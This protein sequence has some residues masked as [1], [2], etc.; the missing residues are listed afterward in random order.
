MTKNSRESVMN[1]RRLWLLV[2]IV[3]LL[4]G[5][6]LFVYSQS[7][8][9]FGD[10]GFHLLAAQL[11]NAGKAPYIDF[12]YQQ[13]PLYPFL[14]GRWM[15]IFGETWRSAHV[16]SVLLVFSTT[17]VLAGILFS[18]SQ[19]SN[20][21]QAISIG[22]LLFFALDTQ[23]YDLSL[24]ADPYVLCLLLSVVAY[25]V[26]IRA[27]DGQRPYLAFVAGLFASGSAASSLLTAPIVIVL[28]T[29]LLQRSVS[30][31][32]LKLFLFF[33]SG[34][35][36]PFI[37]FAY[38]LMKAP[39][40]VWFNVFEF[41]L[42]YR[43]LVSGWHYKKTL[44]WDIYTLTIWLNS[45]QGLLLSVLAF[46]G[47]L[48]VRQGEGLG[49]RCRSD[50]SLCIRLLV[51]QGIFSAITTPTFTHYFVFI[52]PYASILASVGVHA[53]L[54]R[55]LTRYNAL[56]FALFLIA[57]FAAS[58]IK[59]AYQYAR[60]LKRSQ[61][62]Y[63]KQIEDVADV[64]QRISSN[65]RNVYAYEEVYFAAGIHPPEG[66]SCSFTKDIPLGPRRAKLLRLVSEKDIDAK[67]K[68]GNFDVVV[69]GY[70]DPKIDSLNLKMTYPRQ[71]QLH[72]YYGHWVFAK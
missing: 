40:Q 57:A 9:T 34:A 21:Y 70:D 61:R 35:I 12:F 45:T 42:I 58:D 53:I 1:Y 6:A 48:F 68:S 64:A 23:I 59:R 72:G 49:Q 32:R 24:S 37:P 4:Q 29:W 38:F 56:F 65:Y 10:E 41:Q 69:V 25:G 63:W 15:A 67:L 62:Y 2:C 7:G 31:Y 30:H 20:R 18:R 47:A 51:V 28:G 27:V 13:T 26:T 5:I 44:K 39:E 19:G 8:D 36:I 14:V 46:L 55:L 22:A 52:L 66:L 60:S 50:L 43:R 3:I 71:V 11:I 54:T 16:F 33:I 17:I